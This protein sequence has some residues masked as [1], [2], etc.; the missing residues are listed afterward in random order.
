[1]LLINYETN[2][3]LNWFGKCVLSNAKATT[4]AITNTKLY[5]PAVTLSK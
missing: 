3:L 4:F 2:F 1:M 5:V